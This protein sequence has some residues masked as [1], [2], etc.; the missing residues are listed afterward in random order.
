MQLC[1]RSEA[2]AGVLA[3]VTSQAETRSGTHL[4]GKGRKQCGPER[5][6]W[7]LQKNESHAQKESGPAGRSQAWKECF[8]D[9]DKKKARQPSAPK[10]DVMLCYI[11]L[12]HCVNA[13]MCN[14][15]LTTCAASAFASVVKLR[16]LHN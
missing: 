15:C 5:D 1:R 11:L 16:A 13:S 14:D 9:E 7:L 6:A 3:A 4:P 10:H 2:R 12:V 8:A